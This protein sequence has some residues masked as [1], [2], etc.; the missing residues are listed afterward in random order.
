MD[1]S[2]VV[3]SL[4]DQMH[5]AVCMH[6]AYVAWRKAAANLRRCYYVINSQFKN[7]YNSPTPSQG[8]GKLNYLIYNTQVTTQNKNVP[9][10][11]V[12]WSRGI[13][14]SS[15]SSLLN[16]N[17]R[18]WGMEPNA[19]TIIGTSIT[20]TFHRCWIAICKSRYLSN[21]SVVFSFTR[22]SPGIATSTK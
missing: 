6:P 20:V 13:I 7:W 15:K 18:S 12:F 19:P 2:V 21:F 11:T 9:N 16:H 3:A 22:V 17:K 8:I 5:V 1:E 10:N 14:V 4:E